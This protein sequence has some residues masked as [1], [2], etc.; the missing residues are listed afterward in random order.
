MKKKKI[1][2]I[3]LGVIALVSIA[4]FFIYQKYTDDKLNPKN[5]LGSAQ[6]IKND[7]G[8]PK[9]V[10]IEKEGYYDIKTISGDKEFVASPTPPVG[11]KWFGQYFK[12][13]SYISFETNGVIELT[14]AALESLKVSE[15]TFEIKETGNYYSE[16]QI[17]IG[18]YEVTYEGSLADI[19]GGKTD[20]IKAYGNIAIKKL[21]Y[22]DE[23][24]GEGTVGGY[25]F[26]KDKK[27][28][29]ISIGKNQRL[30][31]KS[32]DKDFKFIFKKVK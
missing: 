10:L 21:G 17:P 18:D 29:K 13:D 25:D 8:Q 26:T 20:T 7:T 9:N 27:E 12:K 2:F 14:P 5:N 23:H 6:T 22:F 3:V 28:M 32:T 16:L 19:S 11:K 31:I 15:N 4:A 30:R 24:S 1:I